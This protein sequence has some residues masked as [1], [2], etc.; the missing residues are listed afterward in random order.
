VFVMVRNLILADQGPDYL[1]GAI[2]IHLKS[3]IF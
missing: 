2:V 1:K 3:T